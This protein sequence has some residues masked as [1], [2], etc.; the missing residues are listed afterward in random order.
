MNAPD[1]IAVLFE[2]RG[3]ERAEACKNYFLKFTVR[4]QA[5]GTRNYLRS[6]DSKQ[7]HRPRLT[8]EPFA[9]AANLKING[10]FDNNQSTDLAADLRPNQQGKVILACWR[11]MSIGRIY[12]LAED[13]SFQ[14]CASASWS[15]LHAR[16]P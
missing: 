5:A 8:L 6:K 3:E 11:H 14:Q 7:S 10:R 15:D 12:G 2:H 13:R 9:K 4:F 16:L 1:I